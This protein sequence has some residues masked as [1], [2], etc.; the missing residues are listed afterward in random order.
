[1]QNDYFIRLGKKLGDPSRSIM[2]YWATLRTSWDGKKVSN[3]P[4]YW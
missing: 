3:I 2:S 4:T 1:M